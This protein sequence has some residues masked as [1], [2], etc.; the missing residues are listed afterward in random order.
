MGY[1]TYYTLEVTVRPNDLGKEIVKPGCEHEIV[2][3]AFFC[4]VCGK[5]VFRGDIAAA[6][7][8]AI[9]GLEGQES[10]M[11]QALMQ[12]ESCQWYG[13]DADMVGLSCE[14][15]D[16]VL[17]LTGAGEE[18]ADMWRRYYQ[19]GKAQVAK[20][21]ITYPDFDPALLQLLPR[22]VAT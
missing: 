7:W 2:E 1:Y 19:N 12:R 13:Y 8:N 22:E 16:A 3:G 5:P 11:Y 17:M 6:V 15:P 10:E 21:I 9:E 20:A 14:F 18:N 4:H